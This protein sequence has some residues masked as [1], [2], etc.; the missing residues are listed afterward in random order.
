MALKSP[1][2]LVSV[3]PV[4]A[5][6]WWSRQALKCAAVS[7]RLKERSEDKAVLRDD[8]LR[9]PPVNYLAREVGGFTNRKMQNMFLVTREVTLSTESNS[10]FVKT[11]NAV[12][13]NVIFEVIS[14][15]SIVYG[16]WQSVN[17]IDIPVPILITIGLI[18]AAVIVNLGITTFKRVSAKP[19]P[20]PKSAFV[21]FRGAA[22]WK[23]FDR[24]QVTNELA[25]LLKASTDKHVLLVSPSGTGK[26]TMLYDLLPSKMGEYHIRHFDRYDDVIEDLLLEL[27]A[28]QDDDT[29]TERILAC[30]RQI[31]MAGSNHEDRYNEIEEIIQA[32]SPSK[33]LLLCFDQVERYFLKFDDTSGDDYKRIMNEHTL[34]KRLLKALATNERIRTLFAVRS[35]YIFGSLSSMFNLQPN[36]SNVDEYVEFYFLW[37]INFIDDKSDYANISKRL[38]TKYKGVALRER[39]F[40]VCQI[41]S[42]MKA[43]TFM[44]NLG[45]YLFDSF[46]DRPRFFDRLLKPKLSSDEVIDVFLDAAYDGWIATSGLS[47]RTLFDTVLYALANENRV[48]GQACNQSRLAGLAHY[49]E[50]D[51]MRTVAYLEDVKIV[52]VDGSDI[53]KAYRVAHE[54]L[55]DRLLKSDKLQLDSRAIDGIRYL[56]ENRVRTDALTIPSAFPNSLDI[57]AFRSANVSY[58]AVVIF[59]FFGLFRCLFPDATLSLLNRAGVQHFVESVSGY[60]LHAYYLQPAMY[61]PHFIAHVAWVSYIDRVN[62]AY[63]KWAAPN[64]FFRISG[65]FLSVVGTVLGIA[66]SFTPEL[67]VI[68]I[69]TVGILYGLLLMALSR[70]YSLGG[71]IKSITLAWGYRSIIN[72]LVVLGL[73]HFFLSPLFA[74]ESETGVVDPDRISNILALIIFESAMMVWFWQHIKAEQNSRKIWSANLALLDK[75]R[76]FGR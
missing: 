42:Q 76:E 8:L 47:D 16:Y 51:V 71:Q 58:L 15:A 5:G 20:E 43:N 46:Q 17:Q 32:I 13:N 18:L 66:V 33:N 37:G 35:E 38:Q 62:R 7:V 9:G 27:Q 48:S 40:E 60:H 53:E 56:T 59:V 70:S 45:G 10:R 31:E 57:P 4:W 28:I 1:D 11:F 41:N 74:I 75:G 63:L 14:V 54:K 67:F 44:L 61:V 26:S 25:D 50:N 52:T 64:R 19:L 30:L 23:A 73:S 49:P 65:M 21:P 55:S 39:L 22:G 68:P 29:L 36:G 34:I 72:V 3:A 12:R 69:V 24:R 2:N 6:C